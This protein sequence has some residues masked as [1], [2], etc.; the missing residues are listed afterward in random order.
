MLTSISGR[1]HYHLPVIILNFV[2]FWSVVHVN[3]E[4][5]QHF[6]SRSMRFASFKVFTRTLTS[7][8][9]LFLRFSG[10][11]ESFQI[12]HSRLRNIEHGT[13]EFSQFNLNTAGIRPTY[14]VLLLKW[15]NHFKLTSFNINFKVS[16][17]WIIYE[18]LRRSSF[19]S[20]YQLT[21]QWEH[22]VTYVL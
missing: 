11:W 12:E 19:L 17:K 18:K 1:D 6:M 22:S 21:S 15:M 13:F 7:T 10:W 4:R 2:R 5:R 3:S 20:L 8:V 16:I 14:S 9:F